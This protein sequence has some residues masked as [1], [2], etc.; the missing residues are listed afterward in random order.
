V[1]RLGVALTA[2]LLTTTS[3]MAQIAPDDVV[4]GTLDFEMTEIISDL[5][6]PW[7][8]TLG[9]DGYLW[10]TERVAGQI[11]RIDPATGEQTVLISIDESEAPGGQDGL[12]GLALHPEFL[13]GTGND[14]VY[15]AYTYSDPDRGANPAFDVEGNPHRYLY[16]KLVRLTY[17]EATDTLGEPLEL[18]VGLPASND[19]NSGRIQIGPEGNLYLSIGDG[20]KG[21]LGNWCVPIEAQR[22]PTAEELEADDYVS[23]QGKVLRIAMDGSVPADNPQIDGLQSHIYTYGHRNPQ[24]LVFGP[25][26]TLYESEH[27][28]KSDDEVNILVP[29][30][31][32]GWPHV[33]GYR[34][35]MA[36]QFAQ[37]SEATTPCAEL[38]FSDITIHPSVPVED[39]TAWTEPMEDPLAALFTV[40]NDWN[41]VDPDCDGID[42][43]C[44][45]TIA[46]S[47]LGF[48]DGDAIPSWNNAIIVSTLK[49][50]SIYV[51]PLS[52]DGQSLRGPVERH[53]QSENRFRDIAISEDG[54]TLYVATDPGG[55]AASMEGGTTFEMQNPGAILAF[56]YRGEDAASAETEAVDTDETATE[57]E[58]A[59]DGA[60]APSFTEEQA[61]SGADLYAANCASCHGGNLLAANYGPPLAGDFFARRWNGRT[62]LEL[63]EKVM[64]MPPSRAGQL[65]DEAYRDLTAHIL[66]VNGYAAGQEALPA[67]QAQQ[68]QM[69]L[70]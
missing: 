10:T 49:H 44:W 62:V 59:A 33:A 23:Y 47:S 18:L 22:L 17:D 46:P 68:E 26:G 11:S 52:E 54:L 12:L 21:Q 55:V 65:G 50:G 6:A 57:T 3:A 39:E 29:G 24:G 28:P 19:H 13:E 58:A 16:M 2:A 70:R 9:P 5:G 60:L 35:D 32:Y 63:V 61:A 8:I 66:S 30:G 38:E 56:T 69:I 15:T 40:P 48:Y 64:T 51:L 53:F 20:G 45:P 42:F 14:Y 67:D 36:Y 37:W 7:E 31:N 43:I 25:D 4:M 27:G 1:K 41:F 34:D